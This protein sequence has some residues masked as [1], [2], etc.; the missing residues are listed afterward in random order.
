[1]PR[2]YADHRRLQA[3][4][5][6]EYVLAVVDRLGPLPRSATPILREA[7]RANGELEDLATAIEALRG[8]PRSR[9]ELFRLQRRRI[10]LR[11]QL[12]A[13]ERRLEELAQNRHDAGT[14]LAAYL[15]SKYTASDGH[16]TPAEAEARQ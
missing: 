1:V 16:G 14:D 3:L 7:G 8:K 5:Y 2:A 12:L 11:S 4:Q 9:R 15:N 10:A 6:R 13:L